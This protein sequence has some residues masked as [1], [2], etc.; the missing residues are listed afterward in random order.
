M[1]RALESNFWGL[2]ASI[3][4]SYETLSYLSGKRFPTVSTFCARTK[5]RRTLL[6]LWTIGLALH[7]WKHQ[8][9]MEN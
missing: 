2:S 5:R 4:G 3:L 9:E 6:A 7:V 8:I 1:N